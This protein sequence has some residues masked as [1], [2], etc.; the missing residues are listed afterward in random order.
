MSYETGAVFYYWLELFETILNVIDFNLKRL[1][2]SVFLF[3][4]HLFVR[5]QQKDVA[6]SIDFKP[7]AH[8][9][10]I[11]IL[12]YVIAGGIAQWKSIRLQI[13][14]S[15]VQPR[16]PPFTSAGCLFDWYYYVAIDLNF[17]RFNMK[18]GEMNILLDGQSLFC[19]FTI[20]IRHPVLRCSYLRIFLSCTVRILDTSADVSRSVPRC[21]LVWCA[22]CL[23]TYDLYFASFSLLVNC[24]F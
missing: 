7:T 17:E 19:P 24:Y 22:V 4:A 13:G 5:E 18:C 20:D 8:V 12:Y 1:H 6:R 16:V 21:P 2:I 15:P 9:I 10:F 23:L 3:I 11:F 14:M